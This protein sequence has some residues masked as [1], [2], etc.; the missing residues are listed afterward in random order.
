MLAEAVMRHTREPRLSCNK[1]KLVE[2]AFVDLDAG[3]QVVVCTS[4]K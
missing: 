1:L 4:G 3:R 2:H